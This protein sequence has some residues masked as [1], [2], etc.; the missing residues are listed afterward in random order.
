VNLPSTDFTIHD[1]SRF[2]LVLASGDAPPGYA[3]Q[4]AAE[5]QALIAHGQPFVVVHADARADEAHEDRKQRG[6]WL[7]HHKQALAALCRAVISV[8]PDA[9]RRAA[10]AAQSL[11][12]E[13]AFGVPMRTAPTVEQA[14]AE[15]LRLLAA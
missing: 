7:K 10:L 12:A 8:E 1:V 2:P 5:M 6:I 15:G 14:C 3:A 4:W 11:I 9:L 13:K